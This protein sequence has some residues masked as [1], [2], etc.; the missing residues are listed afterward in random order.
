MNYRLNRRSCLLASS[1]ILGCRAS[2]RTD[3][4]N[5]SHQR[6][7]SVTPNTT[8]TIYAIGAGH[9]LVGRS[10][11]CNY[12]PEASSIPSIGGYTDPS[13]ETILALRPDIVVGARG[14]IGR[15]FVDALSSRG[16]ECFFPST[17]SIEEVLSMITSLAE[18]LRVA[19][20]GTKLVESIRERLERVSRSNTGRR[21]QT[22]FVLG[23]SP[24]SVAGPGSFSHELLVQAGY[25]NVVKTGPRYPTLGLETV[26]ALDPDAIIDA[27]GSDHSIITADRA[28]W[29]SVR[30]VR[31]RR[32]VV[33]SDDRVLRPG[34]RL[35]EG[36]EILARAAQEW[37][38]N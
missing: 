34:P 30:A 18:L 23:L 19:K 29:T 14:P 26:I 2:E 17:E 15:G 33:V 37:G 1:C 8:E 11:Y 31:E 4:R 35:V 21:L 10:R 25:E 6:T 28:G 24:V 36:V 20:N 5:G 38:N 22:L 12:P 7:I 13:L 9:T 32:V 3:P 16:I 27:S